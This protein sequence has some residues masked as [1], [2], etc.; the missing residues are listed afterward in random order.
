MKVGRNDLCHCG[1]GEKYKRCCINSKISFSADTFENYIR[2]CNTSELLKVVSLIQ[3]L[4]ANQSKLIRLETIQDLIC[5]NIK[6]DGKQVNYNEVKRLIMKDYS[7]DYREDPAES[8]GTE[9]IMFFNGNNIVFPGIAKDSTPINQLLINTIFRWENDLPEDLRLTIRDGV[10]FLLHV[11]NVIAERIGLKRYL[12][13]D[14][15]R[16]QISFPKNEF[17][18]NHKDMFEFTRD[19]IQ[20][21][22]NQLHINEDVI[23]HFS[24]TKE[25]LFKHKGEET[26]FVQKPFLEFEDKFYLVLPSAQMYS[27]N[28]FIR[29]QIK[30]SNKIKVLD[31][32][33]EKMVLNESYKYLNVMWDSVDFKIKLRDYES[34]W[35]MDSN[36]FA[37]V[38]FVSEKQNDDIKK[39]AD[40]SIALVRKEL[41]DK[42][43]EFLAVTIFAGYELDRIQTFVIEYLK[44]T[45]YQI[46]L[47]FFDFERLYNKWNPDNLT[48]WKYAKAEE[49][50]EQANLRMAP[51]FSILTYFSWYKRN[52]DSFFPTDEAAPSMV[53]FD[54]STQ[55]TI[56][57]ESAQKSDKHFVMHVENQIGSDSEVKVRYLPVIKTKDYAPIYTSEEIFHRKFRRVL[58]TYPFPIWFSYDQ[59]VGVVGSHFIESIMYWLNE[60]KPTLNPFV[61]NLGNLPIEFILSFDEKLHSFLSSGIDIEKEAKINITYEIDSYLRKVKVKIPIEIFSALHR[62]DNY[63]EQ[64]LMDAVLRAFGVLQSSYKR[65]ELTFSDIERFLRINMPLSGK[66]MLLT[67]HKANDIKRFDRYISKPR[68]IQDAD[69]AIVLE[70][71]VKWMG[72]PYEIP[73]KIK[74]ADKANFLKMMIDTLTAKLKEH[75]VNYDVEDLLQNL[76]FRH[77]AIIQSSSKWDL[78]LPARIKCFEKYQDVIKEY[79]EEYGDVVK[80]SHTLRSLIEY[81]VAECPNGHKR[82]NDDDID[83]LLALTNE[84]I[85]YGTVKDGISFG[86]DNPEMGLLPSGRLGINH[87]FHDTVIA[88]Y[89]NS[90]LADEI[91]NIKEDFNGQFNDDEIEE[92]TDA[93]RKAY[94]ERVSNIFE[95]ELGVDFYQIQVISEFLSTHC[96]RMNTSVLKCSEATTID[97]IIAHSTLSREEVLA[98]LSFMTLE[99]RGQ[100][101]NVPENFHS[102]EIWVW[103]FNR[104]L[105]YI[106]RP[107]VKLKREGTSEVLMWSARHL[108]MASNNLRALFY[109]GMLKVDEVKYPKITALINDR[110]NIKSKDFRKKVL[111]WF[112]TSSLQVFDSE[113]KIRP[114]VFPAAERDYGD[115]DILIIDHVGKK[116][117]L[118]ECKNTKQAKILYDFHHDADNY[119]KKQL[120]RHITRTEFI[121]NNISELGNKVRQDLTEYAV[122][123]VV[124]SSHQL[125]AKFLKELPLSLYSFSEI[126]RDFN[127]IFLK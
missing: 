104:Q 43:V 106:R 5:S 61:S 92:E 126:K 114:S 2:I 22:Y 55:A 57:A 44:E 117:Y 25:K 56:I 32:C 40:S 97:L 115:I 79:K 7:S 98:Y 21:I 35:Q 110:L 66:K 19:E 109:N 46:A 12:F 118:A 68:H 59:S 88:E 26:L 13:E 85:N 122:I 62:S 103:R 78:D 23:T 9:N 54:F 17:I 72:L 41:E 76:M 107:I 125:P 34:F 81:V 14:D 77:E 99:S 48:L 30:A 112:K 102:K 15:W 127:S 28:L 6:T 3:L 121:R 74:D 64:L 90:I 18:N 53:S 67:S 93:K 84:I 47:S 108:E 113:I 49:R 96:F 91:Q 38:R 51:M 71:Q 124:I 36:K 65:K 83:F 27:L 8:C 16:G 123:P 63:G 4:P 37:Y 86:I 29:N 11:H 111:D 120:P 80:A 58:E 119:F 70:S 45:K 39:R 60:F 31:S 10:H 105:S 82:I 100:I 101:E 24:I 94:Y 116:V 52:H 50:A 33:Y 87:D 73:A 20:A 75:L 89:K 1:S 69:I 42:E 95:Q